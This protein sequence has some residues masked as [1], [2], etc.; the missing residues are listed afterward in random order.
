[1]KIIGFIWLEQFIE[2][3]F[4]KHG[5][6]TDE[7]EAVFY[8]QPRIEKAGSGTV[9]GENLYRAL[10]QTEDGRYLTIIFVYKPVQQK[11]LVISAR[12]M[13]RKERKRYEREK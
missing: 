6:E 13:D 5:V 2:K 7:V 11:V 10:G 12:D 9:Q 1:M 4:V 8:N 3:L